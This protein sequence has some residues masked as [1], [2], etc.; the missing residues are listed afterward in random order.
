MK[1]HSTSTETQKLSYEI[2]DNII[3]SNYTGKYEPSKEELYQARNSSTHPPISNFVHE[4]SKNVRQEE[5]WETLV[6]LIRN[7]NDAEIQKTIKILGWKI[8]TPEDGISNYSP[9]YIEA[10]KLVFKILNERN[11]ITEGEKKICYLQ[12]FKLTS[13]M[14]DEEKTKLFEKLEDKPLI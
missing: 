6:K 2:I 10:D 4:N 3:K 9:A 14:D 5:R 13:E 7:S 11:P 8:T 12:I 1:R